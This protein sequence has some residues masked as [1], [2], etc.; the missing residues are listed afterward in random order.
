MH[1]DAHVWQAMF[2]MG[3]YQKTAFKPENNANEHPKGNAL[4]KDGQK[5]RPRVLGI[6]SRAHD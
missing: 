1:L 2:W 4:S 3:Q 5:H 6:E